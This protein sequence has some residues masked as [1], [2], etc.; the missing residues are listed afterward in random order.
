M[1]RLTI[2]SHKD[3]SASVLHRGRVIQRY[4]GRGFVPAAELAAIFAQA[5]RAA[6]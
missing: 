3:G 1:G 4:D 6:A 2:R 5:W